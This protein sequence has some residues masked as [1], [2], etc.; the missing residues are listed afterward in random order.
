MGNKIVISL[1]GSIIC[2]KPG[3][4][5]VKLVKKFVKLI[6]GLTKRGFQFFIVTG[7]GAT[8]RQYIAAARKL[9]WV[10]N[11]DLD[12]M[13]ISATKLNAQLLTSAFGRLAR[14]GIINDPSEASG[15]LSQ[16]NVVSGWKPGWSTDYVAV[17]IARNYHVMTVI[18][19]SNIDYVYDFDPKKRRAAKKILSLSWAEYSRRFGTKWNPG[20]NLPFDP[21]GAKLAAKSGINV[22]IINGQKLGNVKQAILNKKFVGTIIHKWSPTA[23]AVVPHTRL[24]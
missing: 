19:L 15:K 14:K 20:K 11:F 17:Q 24:R 16:V 3:Q 10:S 2:P 1:G 21:V 13:G 22:W 12:W 23:K 9:G 8:A 6:S 18:N 7:G 4:I 5:D